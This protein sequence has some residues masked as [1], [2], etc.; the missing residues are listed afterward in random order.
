MLLLKAY[1]GPQKGRYAS[2]DKQIKSASNS[3]FVGTP[4][5]L[6]VVD[7]QHRGGAGSEEKK[8]HS[9]VS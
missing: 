1:S 5:K 6:A 4:Q 7:E 2:Y 3:A 9:V 8:T